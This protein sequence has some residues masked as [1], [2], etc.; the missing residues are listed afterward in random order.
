[1]INPADPTVVNFRWAIKFNRSGNDHDPLDPWVLY[2]G[3]IQTP[4]DFNS[5]NFCLPMRLRST[6]EVNSLVAYS[7]RSIGERTQFSGRVC[8]FY[9][10]DD[11]SSGIC[12]NE[13]ID[14]PRLSTAGQ[15]V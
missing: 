9:L 15:Q 12:A 2:M 11:Q 3:R 7:P 8:T 5:C 10:N 13:K 6:G 4:R 14:L 1:L